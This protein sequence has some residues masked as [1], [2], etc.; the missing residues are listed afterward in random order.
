MCNN[1]SEQTICININNNDIFDNID[2]YDKFLLNL[3]KS[4]S[5]RSE[6]ISKNN[7][8]KPLIYISLN[9]D[10][11]FN[12]DITNEEKKNLFKIGYDKSYT[13]INQYINKKKCKNKNLLNFCFQQIKSNYI[14]CSN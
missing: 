5:N 9:L 12:L 8:K 14:K 10:P 1:E 7:H 4:V 13:D 2:T 3:F 6:N 11:T